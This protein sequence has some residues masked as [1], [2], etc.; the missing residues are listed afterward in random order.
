MMLNN[1]LSGISSCPINLVGIKSAGSIEQYPV[2]ISTPISLEPRH[3]M[4]LITRLLLS[5][6][7]NADLTTNDLRIISILTN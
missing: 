5:K 4:S 2:T 3:V 1:Q 6:I 7:C